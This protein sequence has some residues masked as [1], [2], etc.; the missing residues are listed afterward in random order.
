MWYRGKP[1]LHDHNTR[2]AHGRANDRQ[3]NATEIRYLYHS[4][5]YSIRKIVRL[6]V[7]ITHVTYLSKYSAAGIP[8]LVKPIEESFTGY[9]IKTQFKAKICCLSCLELRIIKG[10]NWL[11]A[12]E[13]QLI[14]LA[15]N[16]PV[17]FDGRLT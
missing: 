14:H 2:Y 1:Y 13:G 4:D 17:Q 7:G 8:A 9:F 10:K 3:Q 11:S 12:A 6:P 15:F 5:R 16:D